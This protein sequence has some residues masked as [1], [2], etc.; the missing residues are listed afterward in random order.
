MAKVTTSLFG[1][2]AILP[3]QAEA[4][5]KESL[6]FLTDVIE[7]HDSTEQRLQLRSKPRQTFNYTMPLQAWKAAAAFNTEYGAIR[8]DWA[9]P[10]WTEAQYIGTVG[11][12]LLSINCNTSLY[13]LRPQSLAMLYN[14]C[15][16]FQVIEIDEVFSTYITLLADSE[17]V[18]NAWLMPV[19]KGWIQGNIDKPTSGHNGKSTLAFL[20]D[21][22]PVIA[23]TVPTQYLSDDIYYDIP[24]LNSGSLS[25]SLS[26][27]QD[28]VDME[29][30]PI[31]RRTHWDRP[32]YGKPWRSILTTPQEIRDYRKFLCRRAG[33]LRRFW[34]PTFENNMRVTSTG[35]ITTTLVI[36]SDSFINYALPR[37]HIAFEANGLWYPREISS[38]TQIDPQHVQFTLSSALNVKAEQIARISYLGLHRFDADRIEL[39]WQGGGVVEASVQVLELSP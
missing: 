25:A 13:D 39:N 5:I 12:G 8:K 37:T 34:F 10:I 32:R 3:Y 35:T 31:G 33:K 9:I 27:N 36:E 28:I 4:P 23:P 30:G 14:P 29:L 17:F 21:D 16:D 26:Q 2:L 7:A 6:E 20:V 38:P 22:N 1:E 24:L 18:A 11:A 19:R 15:G